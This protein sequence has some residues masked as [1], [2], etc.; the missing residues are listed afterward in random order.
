MPIF[1]R[2]TKYRL[3]EISRMPYWADDSTQAEHNHAAEV[4]SV[5]IGDDVLPSQ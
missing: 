3:P 2:V 4:N 5:D 1:R